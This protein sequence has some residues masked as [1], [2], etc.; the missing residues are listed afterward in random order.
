V[1]GNGGGGTRRRATVTTADPDDEGVTDP[2]TGEVTH[3]AERLI[4]RPQ[5]GR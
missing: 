4:A 5:G 2:Q 1:G 3:P